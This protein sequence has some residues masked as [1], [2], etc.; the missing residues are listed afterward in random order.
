LLLYPVQAAKIHTAILITFFSKYL[1]GIA[2]INQID[3]N[4]FIIFSIE[5]SSRY[6]WDGSVNNL[7]AI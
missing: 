2:A 7:P 6:G 3:L 5:F 4:T 1:G